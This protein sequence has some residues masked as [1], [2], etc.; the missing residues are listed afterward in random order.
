MKRTNRNRIIPVEF[1]AL[2]VSVSV[3]CRIEKSCNNSPL[4]LTLLVTTVL[5]QKLSS[6]SRTFA[7]RDFDETWKHWVFS[8]YSKFSYSIKAV[9]NFEILFLIYDT[10][11]LS[12]SLIF[13]CMSMLFLVIFSPGLDI[14]SNHGI[15]CRN[16]MWTCHCE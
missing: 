13:F 14:L 16:I 3:A 15:H 7:S 6:I 12:S 5:E 2:T 1:V 10:S 8:K 9:H 11:V 4:M